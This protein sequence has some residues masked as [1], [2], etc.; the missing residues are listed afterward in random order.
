MSL[1]YNV[2]SLFVRKLATFLTCFAIA[3]SVAVL[4]LVL[5]MA[6]GFELALAE[7][8]RDDNAVVL[9]RGSQSEGVS[10]L[11][12]DEARTL[13]A[14]PQLAKQSDGTV[15]AEAELYAGL[16]IEKSTGGFTNI[17]LRGVQAKTVLAIRDTVKIREGRL[18]T[19]G[20]NEVVVGKGLL[21][22]VQG[23]RLGGAITLAGRDWPVVGIVDSNGAAYDSEIWGDVEVVINAFDRKGYNLVIGRLREGVTMAS[24][25]TDIE[26]DQRFTAKA[27][28][29]RAYFV[30]QAGG[31]GLAMKVLAWF[32]AAIMAV[33][34]VFGA[35]NTLYASVAART[36]EIG[37]MLAIGFK[38]IAVFFGFLVESLLL[39]L[40]GGGLG[41]LLAL[42]AH[43]MTTGTTNW[44]TFT[45]QTFAFR[46]T[47]SVVLAALSLALVIGLV[48]GA[49]PAL[50]ASRLE[51]VK[52]L[53]SL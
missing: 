39:S 17:P 6:K 53:Q 1:L 18:F 38:P 30:S 52:A 48:G 46:V 14:L 47:P 7:T 31:L 15:L 43:G 32:L 22:R 23:C 21:E 16:S 28:S 42:P 10:G 36:R 34:S 37:T 26:A 51:P 9:R 44:Q 11:S 4:V 25:A 41:L 45:E 2:R 49:L 40:M 33:G 13:L 29:E 24:F 19:V 5:S 35:A 50:R 3:L 20:T 27:E 12:R 8:G